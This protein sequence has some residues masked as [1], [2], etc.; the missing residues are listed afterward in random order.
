[1]VF[2]CSQN[3]AIARQNEKYIASYSGRY[4]KFL[5]TISYESIQFVTL[6]H[7]K[8]IS[9]NQV[10][11]FVFERGTQYAIRIL[12]RNHMVNRKLYGKQT[13]INKSRTTCCYRR[14]QRFI[15]LLAET[16]QG[17][18]EQR[19]SNDINNALPWV[20]LHILTHVLTWLITIVLSTMYDDSYEENIYNPCMIAY[21]L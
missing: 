2:S 14:S 17:Q 20:C 10:L 3:H 4:R 13:Y 7:D 15:M 19:N 16:G 12:G 8:L 18:A 9:K 21:E 1:M 11:N 6:V 5:K